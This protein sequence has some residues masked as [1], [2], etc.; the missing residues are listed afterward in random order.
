MKKKKKYSH[1]RKTDIQINYPEHCPEAKA[2][3]QELYTQKNYLS[4]Q[5]V[6]RQPFRQ[7]GTCHLFIRAVW[8]INGK[9]KEN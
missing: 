1:R 8:E 2:V 5:K 6:K 9:L 3:Y 4:K 7:K